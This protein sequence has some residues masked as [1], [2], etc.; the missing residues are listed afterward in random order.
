MAVLSGSHS[1]RYSSTVQ[2]VIPLSRCDAEYYAMTKGAAAGS[3][4]RSLFADWGIESKL[5]VYCESSSARSSPA[6]RR[7]GK[8]RHIQTRSLWLQKRVAMKHV[9]VLKF[10]TDD[11]P[12]DLFTKQLDVKKMRKFESVF[13]QILKTNICAV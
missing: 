3:G 11:N 8:Q 9:K 6:M 7:I 4:I 10:G 2:A 12:A 1:L 5:E 13:G